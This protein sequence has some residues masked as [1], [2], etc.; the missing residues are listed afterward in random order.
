[1]PP[2][3]K[4]VPIDWIDIAWTPRIFV[5]APA[6]RTS[7]GSHAF[8]GL[9]LPGTKQGRQ[10]LP[11][12]A[13]S[14]MGCASHWLGRLTADSSLL[15]LSAF[16]QKLM[17]KP[18]NRQSI[19]RGFTLIELLVVISIIAILAAMLLP[20]ISKVKLRALIQRAQ[21]EMNDVKTAISHYESSYS[22]FPVSRGVMNSAA[23]VP[24]GDDFTY[25]TSGL[26]QTV[27]SASGG[28]YSLLAMSG[29]NP[30]TYQTNNA[31]V[32]AVLLDIEAYPNGNPTINKNHVKNPQRSPFLNAKNVSD[33]TSG[34]VGLDGVYRDPWGDPYFITL[35]LNSDGKCMDSFYRLSKVS[36]LS[37]GSQAGRFGLMNTIDSNGAGNHFQYNGDVMIWSAGPDR[38][39][40]DQN[41]ANVGANKDNILSW[42]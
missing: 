15:V 7:I 39:V 11:L 34:G 16:P 37:P 27:K 28:T 3:E 21:N 19:R 17:K 26:T 25:G 40:D 10:S 6:A 5:T 20:V 41:P 2:A 36:Q 42:K 24:P 33:N 1:M 4:V 32:M 12:S 22:T 31:E 35:D 30:G 13:T 18:A 29:N 23:A 14:R 38:T 9:D 8:R